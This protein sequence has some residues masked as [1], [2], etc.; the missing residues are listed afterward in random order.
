MS[1]LIMALAYPAAIA[2][3]FYFAFYRPLQQ[4]RRRQRQTLQS[5]KVGDRVLT[6]GGLIA[7]VKEVVV[8]EEGPTQVV[9][10]LAPGVEVTAL[11]TAIVQRLDTASVMATTEREDE[12]VA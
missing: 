1:L 7:T 10:E 5:L 2:L 12:A 6:Q 8:P 11:A 4:E 9:L 3:L